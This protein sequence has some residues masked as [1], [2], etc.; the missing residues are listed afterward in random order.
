M[1]VGGQNDDEQ[2]TLMN[3]LDLL[4]AAGYFRAR[5]KGLATFDKE[6]LHNKHAIKSHVYGNLLGSCS[7]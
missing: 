3:C 4:I 2:Q 7:R 6:V 1:D 5:I